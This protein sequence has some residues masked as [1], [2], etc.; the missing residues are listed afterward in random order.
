M[1]PSKYKPEYCD[2]LIEHMGSGFSFRSFAGVIKCGIRTM[3]DW[4]DKHPEFK[5]AK[6][7]AQASCHLYY[8]R[9]GNDMSVG[10]I[11]KCNATAF[12]WMTKN[13]LKWSDKEHTSAIDQQPINIKIVEDKDSGDKSS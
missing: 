3:Y 11:E 6:E 2:M 7:I 1:N 4:C 10:N 8:E 13:I 9:L 12:V 5:E